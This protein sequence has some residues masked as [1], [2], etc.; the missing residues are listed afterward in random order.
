MTVASSDRQRE[1][2]YRLHAGRS[3]VL[4]PAWE[5]EGASV[6][7]D[8]NSGD[9]WVIAATTRGWIET[10]IQSGQRMDEAQLQGLSPQTA[11]ADIEQALKQLVSLDI[12][13]LS[14]E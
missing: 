12:F 6:L 13:Q 10:L 11:P 8:R 2:A 7:F 3:F 5:D 1:A 9:Y 4:S 14:N